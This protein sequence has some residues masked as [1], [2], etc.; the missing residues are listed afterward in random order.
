MSKNATLVYLFKGSQILLGS[1]KYGG[2]KGKLNGFGGKIEKE[3]KS[4]SEAAIREVKEETS[5]DIEKINPIGKLNFH[6]KY[7]KEEA[8]I[9]LFKSLN[10]KG[11]AQESKEMSVEWFPI[12]KVPKDRM[13]DSDK[14]WFDYIFQDRPFLIDFYFETENSDL[15]DKMSVIFIKNI[16]EYFKE[17]S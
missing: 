11:V 7:K 8:S 1:K 16:N 2:A 5:L 14:Y 9:Y 15:F 12:N 17:N 4:I 3:D 10:F 13:W 6:W